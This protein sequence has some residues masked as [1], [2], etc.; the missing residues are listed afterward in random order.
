MP[1]RHTPGPKTRHSPKLRATRLRINRQGY[2]SRGRYWGI[3]APVYEVEHDDNGSVFATRAPS[4][5]EAKAKVLKDQGRGH[6]HPYYPG[7]PW[8]EDHS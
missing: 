3:G 1:R 8:P 6:R 4:A 7:Q 2:D 5:K